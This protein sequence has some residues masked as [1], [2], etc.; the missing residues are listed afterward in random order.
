MK[1]W[2]Y[3][4]TYCLLILMGFT[5]GG[6]FVLASTCFTKQKTT[7]C[8]MTTCCC[9]PEAC[10][11]EGHEYSHLNQAQKELITQIN[12]PD[13]SPIKKIITVGFDTS[14]SLVSQP[15]A[16]C[17]GSVM[18]EHPLF[19]APF[20]LSFRAPSIFHPPRIS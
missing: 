12:N 13:C 17:F 7:C 3:Y 18:Q 14:P 15:V 9:K 2:H 20:P 5:H 1:R 16:L 8:A 19:E 4:I 10:H 6:G 11:C